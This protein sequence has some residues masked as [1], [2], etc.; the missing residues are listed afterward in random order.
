MRSGTNAAEK[1]AMHAVSG[2]LRMIEV[3]ASAVLQETRTSRIED[4]MTM[5]DKVSFQ[6]LG[7]Q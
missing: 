3:V 7:Y 4:K 2:L 5:S 1:G 6:S